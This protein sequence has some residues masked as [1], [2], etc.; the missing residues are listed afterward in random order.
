MENEIQIN[1]SCNMYD[2]IRKKAS[3]IINEVDNIKLHIGN[4]IQKL[5]LLFAKSWSLN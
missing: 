3:N 2:N 1:F 5:K 4:T